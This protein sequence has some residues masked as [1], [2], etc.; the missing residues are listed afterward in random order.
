MAA[1]MTLVRPHGPGTERKIMTWTVGGDQRQA[2]VYAPA[3]RAAGSRAPL[4]LSFHGHGDNMQN[5][6]HTDLHRAWPEAVVV[7]FQGLP[8]RDGLSGWQVERVR[9][10]TGI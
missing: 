2:I 6:Q 5:F 9:T 7:Y 10:M 3:R 1:A 8:S 4:V